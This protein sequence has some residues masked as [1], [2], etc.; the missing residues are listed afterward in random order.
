MERPFAHQRTG[1]VALRNMAT[2]FPRQ[3]TRLS[4]VGP[5][6]PF[7]G[8]IAHYTSLLV[9]AL[10]RRCRVQFLSYSRQYPAWLYP[11]ASDRDPSLKPVTL[12]SPDGTF[13]ALS[14]LAWRRLPGKIALHRSELV[15]LPWTVAYWAPFY[16]IFLRALA[17][18]PGPP[19]LF[20]CH[21]VVEHESSGLKNWLSS[22]VLR[23][24]H[25]FLTHSEWDQDNLLGWIG[26]DRA[27]R[28]TVS[29]HP[30]Y[31][32]FNAAEMDPASARGRLG[33]SC[34]RVLLF[35]G[36][37]REYKGLRYL[38]QSLPLILD[39]FPVHLVVAGESWEDVGP[40]RELVERLHLEERVTMHIRYVPDEMVATYFAAADLVVVPYTSATQSGIV[41]LAHGFRK[42]V[43]VGNVGGIPEAVEEGRTGYLVPPRNPEAIAEAVIHFFSSRGGC[44]MPGRIEARLGERS[45][46]RLAGA[47]Q[48]IGRTAA[49]REQA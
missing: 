30:V 3:N 11:G 43:V 7:R 6:H 29:P 24:G 14:P 34:D 5:T 22:R 35:F 17:R 1:T 40:Y 33:V 49:A 44:T 45:W 42:P 37:V 26:P 13:D 28:V 27:D 47:V 12:E 9:R 8:G 25:Y 4:V 41:Q 18:D 20:I 38:L 32:H 2:Q 46:E 39:R 19:A 36:F 10:R 16:Y 31:D 21:N 48:A 15:I 23:R